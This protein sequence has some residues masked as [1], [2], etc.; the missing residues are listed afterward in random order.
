LCTFV[1]A[2]GDIE[3]VLEGGYPIGIEE[4]IGAGDPLDLFATD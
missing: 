1:D 3:D 2:I 4:D